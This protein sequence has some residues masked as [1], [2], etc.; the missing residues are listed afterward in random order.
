MN[1]SG[2]LGVAVTIGSDDK[3]DEDASTAE[4]VELPRAD[5]DDVLQASSEAL[6]TAE[7][8]I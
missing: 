7:E 2:K 4:T 3:A 1:S 8:V 5:E 6:V